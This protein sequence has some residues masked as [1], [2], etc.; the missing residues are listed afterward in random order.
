[1][2]T[3]NCNDDSNLFYTQVDS[4]YFTDSEKQ[5]LEIEELIKG[6]EDLQV[7]IALVN[8]LNIRCIYIQ[9]ILLELLAV[10]DNNR[11]RKHIIS[12]NRHVKIIRFLFKYIR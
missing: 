11:S 6:K 8:L 12:I 2:N 9:Q 3:Q 10:S 1:M 7:S 4:E 5:F